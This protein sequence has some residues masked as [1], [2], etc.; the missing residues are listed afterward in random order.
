MKL[1]TFK[2]LDEHGGS[3]HVF[4]CPGC[5]ELHSYLTDRTKPPSW[6]FNGNFDRPTFEPSLL[7]QGGAGN[8]NCHLFLRDGII[9]YLNDCSHE[10]A[11]QK[12]PLPDIPNEYVL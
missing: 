9:E 8:T 10:L 11:G 3:R 12:I 1:Q 5:R 2:I 4:W 7:C 6:T